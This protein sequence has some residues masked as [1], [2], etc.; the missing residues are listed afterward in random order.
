MHLGLSLESDICFYFSW[1]MYF[2]KSTTR[3]RECLIMATCSQEHVLKVHL[4]DPSVCLAG[5]C[6]S[7]K[8]RCLIR[9][10]QHDP[11]N[12]YSQ[13]ASDPEQILLVSRDGRHIQHPASTN[14]FDGPAHCFALGTILASSYLEINRALNHVCDLNLHLLL[15]ETWCRFMQVFIMPLFSFAGFWSCLSLC[16]GFGGNPHQHRASQHHLN[17]CV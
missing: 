8:I 6:V 9:V 12:S 14:S 11:F 3:E 15:Q 4:G 1:N 7:R 5:H 10:I 2:I 16:L 13:Q 17:T